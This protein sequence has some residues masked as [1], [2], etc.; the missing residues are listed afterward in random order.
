MSIIRT[1]SKI[2]ALTVILASGTTVNAAPMTAGTNRPATAQAGAGTIRILSVSDRRLLREL[3]EPERPASVKP[4][5]SLSKA[6]NQ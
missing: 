6:S 2:L 3:L 4:P 5:V 1:I